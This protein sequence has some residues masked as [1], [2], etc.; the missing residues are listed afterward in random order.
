MEVPSVSDEC[1]YSS[2]QATLQG[3]REIAAPQSASPDGTQTVLPETSGLAPP[4]SSAP[5]LVTSEMVTEQA[6]GSQ[7]PAE[8]LA[9]ADLMESWAATLPLW[10]SEVPEPWFEFLERAYNAETSLAERLRRLPTCRLYMCPRRMEVS[11]KLAGIHVS[12]EQGLAAA[13]RAWARQA[14]KGGRS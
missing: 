5:G 12:T 14:R 8:L 11:L 3:I 7:P 10:E 4:V 2:S 6:V 13:C 9:I 1:V